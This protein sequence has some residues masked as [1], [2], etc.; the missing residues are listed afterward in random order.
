MPRRNRRAPQPRACIK[1][2][3]PAQLASLRGFAREHLEI[4]TASLDRADAGDL[5]VTGSEHP[6]TGI[7]FL[8]VGQRPDEHAIRLTAPVVTSDPAARVAQ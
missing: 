3:T 1:T 7:C 6:G 5:P 2:L 4:H 8:S